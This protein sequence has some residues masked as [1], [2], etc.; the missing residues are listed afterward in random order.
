MGE[1]NGGSKVAIFLAGVGLGAIVA[2][3]FAPTSGEEARKLISRKA[4]ESRRYV[5]EKG[6]AVRRQAEGLVGKAK[7]LVV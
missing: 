2:L 5:S 3:L 1:S 6:R 7:D 4:D